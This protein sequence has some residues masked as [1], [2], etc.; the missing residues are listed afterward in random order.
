MQII[1][2]SPQSQ[3]GKMASQAKKIGYFIIL[4][5]AVIFFT[6]LA[7]TYSTLKAL[8]IIGLI[9]SMIG[10]IIMLPG[11]GL[12]VWGYQMFGAIRKINNK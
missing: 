2:I 7:I 12:M 8:G 4:A 6:G 1:K 11:F 9:P 10:I 3:F 5:G